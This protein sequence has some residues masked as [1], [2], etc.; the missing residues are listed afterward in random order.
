LKRFPFD[1]LKIDQSFVQDITT[2][3]DNAAIATT[4]IAMAH[5]LKM[6]V[7]AEGVETEGQLNY[8]RS[9]GELS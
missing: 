4:V 8:L 7:I 9:H 6:K 2:E 5:S 1:K 3:P